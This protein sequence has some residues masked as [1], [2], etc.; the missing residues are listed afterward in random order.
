MYRLKE[1]PTSDRFPSRARPSRGRNALLIAATAF[2]ILGITIACTQDSNGPAPPSQLPIPVR[3]AAVKETTISRTLTFSGT[4]LPVDQVELVPGIAARVQKINYDVGDI[5]LKGEALVVLDRSSLETQVKQAQ[6]GLMS[7]KAKFDQMLEGARSEDVAAAEAQL[8][9]QRAKLNSLLAGGRPEQVASAEA[10]LKAMKEK[11]SDIEAGAKVHDIRVAQSAVSQAESALAAASA[12][13]QQ[14]SNP[15]ALDIQAAQAGMDAARASLAAAE[16]ARFRLLNPTAEDI[17]SLEASIAS[18]EAGL[19]S[20]EATLDDL[21]ARPKP[22][23]LNAGQAAVAEAKAAYDS[24]LAVM[25]SLKIDLNKEKVKNVINARLRLREARRK[26]EMDKAAGAPQEQLDKDNEELIL[27]Y[28]AVESAEDDLDW[29]KLGVSTDDILVAQANIDATLSRL[30]SAQQNLETTKQ[31][32]TQAQIRSAELLVEQARSSLISTQT[33]H[34]DLTNPASNVRQTTDTMVETARAGL[35]GAQT[36]LEQLKN[37]RPAD[38]QAARSA[39]DG[40]KATLDAAQARLDNLLKGATQAELEQA[41]AA[42]VQADMQL[43]LTRSPYT[44]ND[45]R[46][47]EELI[48]QLASQYSKAASP[49]TA[50][51][52]DVATASVAMAEAAL[53]NAK[54]LADNAVITAPFDAVVAKKYLSPG[55]MASPQTPVLSLVSQSMKVEFSAEEAAVGLLKSG[56][57]TLITFPSY[58]DERFAGIVSNLSPTADPTTRAFTGTVTPSEGGSFLKGG[59]YTNIEVILGAKPSARVVPSE[60]VLEKDGKSVVFVIT[61]G[62]VQMREIKVGIRSSTVVEVSSGLDLGD[63]I[64]VQGVKSVKDGDRVRVLE[65]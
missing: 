11:L 2:L 42:V 45:I 63:N 16:A 31:G 22:E 7:A 49:Y 44:I 53:E 27:A 61:D 56:Q 18:A 54:I 36:K 24:T 58:P 17:E 28:R 9:A 25:E 59:M 1:T 57:K 34:T 5:V 4:V 35:V 32:P 20:A 33:K 43:S 10:S 60:A 12:H 64:V 26:L 3:A 38:F 29:T 8:E 15:S 51:D 23:E 30:K 19:R 39:E 13:L 47:Q 14:L 41:R 46:A 6:A 62:I 48:N 40:A 37:P 55:A 52:I 50:G 21:R 65:R